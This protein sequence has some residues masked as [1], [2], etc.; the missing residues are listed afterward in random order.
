M[1]KYIPVLGPWLTGVVEENVGRRIFSQAQASV[2]NSVYFTLALACVIGAGLLTNA[3]E[4]ATWVVD[5]MIITSAIQVCFGIISGIRAG[6]LAHDQFQSNWL[7]R[8]SGATLVGSI[9]AVIIPLGGLAL[10]WVLASTMKNWLG[11]EFGGGFF[12]W[13]KVETMQLIE[14]LR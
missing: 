1:L 10:F 9:Q 2:I 6:I 12:E 7:V 3:K 8:L 11:Q 5:A 13:L 14:H 4:M